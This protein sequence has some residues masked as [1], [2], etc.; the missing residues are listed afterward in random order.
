MMRATAVGSW[1]V[2]MRKA[3]PELV[4][5]EAARRSIEEEHAPGQTLVLVTKFPTHSFVR[6]V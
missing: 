1:V 3:F 6:I 2:F 5:A 4:E